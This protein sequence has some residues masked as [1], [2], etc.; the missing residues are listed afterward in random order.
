MYK[1]RGPGPL[2]SHYTM[3]S[4]FEESLVKQEARER[5]MA[6]EN[7]VRGIQGNDGGCFPHQNHQML[8]EGTAAEY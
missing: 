8:D 4:P 6:R 2:G 1:K 3:M 7:Y 5:T